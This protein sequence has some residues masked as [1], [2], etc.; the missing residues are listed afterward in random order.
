MADDVAGLRRSGDPKK[1][2]VAVGIPIRVPEIDA[3]GGNI[4]E[5]SP[6]RPKFDEGVHVWQGK[7]FVVEEVAFFSRNT[8]QS[9]GYTVHDLRRKYPTDADESAASPMVFTTFNLP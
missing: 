5:L 7:G 6:I 9:T 3:D 1:V 2:V 8:D 4:I